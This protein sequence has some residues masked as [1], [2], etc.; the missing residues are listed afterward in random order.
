MEEKEA[1]QG[2]T[3]SDRVMSP[4]PAGGLGSRVCLAQGQVSLVFIPLDLSV[5]G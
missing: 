2:C 5:T 3:K 1:K 4:Q